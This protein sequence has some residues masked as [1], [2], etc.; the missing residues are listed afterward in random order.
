MM[1]QNN[2]S[3]DKH[4]INTPTQNFF[5][6]EMADKCVGVYLLCLVLVSILF[7][8]FAL[9]LWLW[10]FSI[11]SVIL[12]FYGSNYFT[13]KWYNNSE[14]IFTKN[15]FG[16]ALIIRLLYVLFIYFF[17]WE[18]YGTFYESSEGDIT[19]YVPKAL[20]LAQQISDGKVIEIIKNLFFW[21]GDISDSGYIF[22]LS[23]IYFLTGGYSD[24]ILPLILKAIYGAITCILIYRI[25][26]RHFGEY[27]GRLAAIFCMLHTSMIWW[28]GSMMK[29][30]EMILIFTCFVYEMDRVLSLGKLKIKNMIG[31]TL[32]GLVLFT[33]R[34]ALAIVAFASLFIAIVLTSRKIINWST[35]IFV[36]VVFAVVLGLSAWDNMRSFSEVA[37]QQ[38]IE[39]DTQ[40]LNMEWRAKR[41]N[42][43]EFAKYA[44]AA[45]FAPMIF[46]I[47]FPSMVYTFQ[48]Q[49]MHMMVN[50][51]YYAKNIL[52]FFVILVM[53]IL[54][55]SGEWRKHVFIIS[56]MLGYLV[57]LVF[58]NFAQSGRFHM[59]VLA[60]ELMFAAYG[61]HI[62]YKKTIYRQWFNYALA[63]EIVICVAWSWFKLAGRGW[64]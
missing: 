63:L 28:C 50:G 51:G 22:Y 57:V 7:S 36:G 49:E 33:F 37:Q 64:I 40:T 56:V 47:P 1:Q 6:I 16:V 54:L 15:L 32:L 26:K 52:S 8:N 4:L 3:F 13:R 21:G 29:E 20:Q 19:F 12:F 31:A 59:P 45:V 2:V 34:T 46:T 44:G 53:F 9:P 55:L 30:T 41:L 35:K 17:N 48:G 18:H 61:I 11:T 24:V 39:S 43:N 42:G 62:L 25:G 38:V 60:L 10:I 23:I 27:A 5:P 14:K 58:S